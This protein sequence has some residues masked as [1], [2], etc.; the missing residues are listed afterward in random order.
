[1]TLLRVAHIGDHT[2]IYWG[3][4]EAIDVD[5]AALLGVNRNV[6]VRMHLFLIGDIQTFHGSVIPTP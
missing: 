2:L 4:A 3:S 5:G 6:S 1:M